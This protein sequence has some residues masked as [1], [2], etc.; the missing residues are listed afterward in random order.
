M[1]YEQIMTAL[2]NADKA[3]DTEAATR[4]AQ[5]AK[6]TRPIPSKYPEGTEILAEV[7]GGQVYQL[8]SGQRGFSG[9]GYSTTDPEKIEKI[10]QGVPA[11]TVSKAGFYE[12]I[13]AQHPIAARGATA[14]QGV[15]FAG[16]YLGEAIGATFGPKAQQAT[17]ASQQAMAQV[18][19]KETMGLQI[20]TGIA[21]ALPMAVAAAPTIASWMPA[22][23]GM[24][25]LA[26]GGFGALGGGLEG[27]VSGYG[28][29]EG[30]TRGQE[31][32]RRGVF[33]ATLGG[34]MGLAAPVIGA[35]VRKGVEAFKAS[36]TIQ[37][38]KQA[39]IDESSA[40]MLSSVV[41]ADLS[42]AE[43]NIRAAGPAAMVADA[44]PNTKQLLDL[45]I[46]GSGPASTQAREAV[47]NRAS[48]AGRDLVAA[49]DDALGTP[50]GIKSIQREV[51]Q[52]SAG[53]RGTAYDAA[54]ATPIN[55]ASAAGRK[56]EELL[57]RVPDRIIRNAEGMM[58]AEGMSSAQIKAVIGEGGETVFE[59]LPDV[60]QIDYITRALRDEA[61]GAARA[62]TGDLGRVYKGLSRDIRNTLG[63]DDL[64]PEY[65][66]ARSVA[67][68]AIS[69]REAVQ[70]GRE[71]LLTRTTREDVAEAVSDMGF[72]E[73]MRTKQGVRGYVDDIMAN[74]KRALTDNNMDAREAL[75]PLSEMTTR[76]GREKLAL[77]LGDEAS[78]SLQ[79]QMDEIYNSL[80][81]RAS[82]AQNS[83]TFVRQEFG[84][85]RGELTQPGAMETLLGEGKPIESAQKMMA[86]AL[87]ADPM[88]KVL[89]EQQIMSNLAGVLTSDASPEAAA[90]SFAQMGPSLA[91][92]R[93]AGDV[94]GQRAVAGIAGGAFPALTQQA[95]VAGPTKIAARVAE[96]R[97]GGVTDQTEIANILRR[98]GLI[99]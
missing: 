95:A 40:R 13:I 66:T 76:A 23:M 75:R 72:D 2:R 60:R 36:P 38:I 83:K 87:G 44:G 33:G 78:A 43:R 18:R 62:G 69:Q 71:L 57:D 47:Q 58:R 52:S 14:L 32:M 17:E 97:E 94:A 91:R 9:P 81:L 35:G 84:R 88:E 24:K 16:E 20:G 82:L 41:D 22:S 6:E 7:E 55:Y 3:G 5:M 56:L 74:A 80:A 15:P 59:T 99:E 1:T 54:Y 73:L 26:G 46:Q 93:A 25:I 85:M 67:A 34:V 92:A 21:S 51:M 11:G 48:A 98:E 64:V 30:D 28:A 4:F 39:G 49:L 10:L 86:G 31:S 79:K 27:F 68:D 19:P 45:A 89:R 63:G 12:D 29:G 8:P 96:L 70:T 42:V 50:A 90:R 77:L 61:G 37:A 65:T 53:A